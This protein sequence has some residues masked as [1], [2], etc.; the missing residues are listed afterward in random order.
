[1]RKLT[2]YNIFQQ[3]NACGWSY[4]AFS[5]WH[6]ER[7][8]TL[9]NQAV[10]QAARENQSPA[11]FGKDMC[12]SRGNSVTVK[13]IPFGPLTAWPACVISLWPQVFTAVIVYILIQIL[14]CKCVLWCKHGV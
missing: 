1:M 10:L 13:I 14:N 8:G 7:K 4:I 2:T 3:K 5:S 11:V 12:G 6:K 9:D